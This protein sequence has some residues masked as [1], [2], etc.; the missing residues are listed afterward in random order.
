MGRLGGAEDFGASWMTEKV[1]GAHETGHVAGHVK[2]FDATKGFGFV[3]S[4]QGGP[5]ILLHSN[6]LRNYG[7]GSVADQSRIELRVQETERGLQ[8]TEILS[9]EPPTGG[10]DEMLDGVAAE[11]VSDLPLQPARV[12]W[13]DKAKGFGFANSFGETEDIFLHVEVLRRCGLADL[14]AGEAVC[15]RIVEGGRGQMAAA[16]YSWDHATQN[17]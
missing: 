8:A 11:D 14:Q 4:D 17:T 2:W 16:V 3:V 13:F 6:V 15:L 1:Q 12:K 5:D 9:L 10:D 7:Q